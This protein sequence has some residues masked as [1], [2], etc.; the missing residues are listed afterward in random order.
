MQ[1]QIDGPDLHA[2]MIESEAVAIDPLL[3]APIRGRRAVS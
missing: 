1:E 3:R 2:G